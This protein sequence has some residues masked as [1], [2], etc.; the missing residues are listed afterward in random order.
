MP[1]RFLRPLLVVEFL[2]A[3]LAWLT[4]WS[5]VGGQYHLDLMFWPWKL[6][7][8]IAAAA[9]VCAFTADLVRN[10]GSVS[11]RAVLYVALLVIL[12][13]TA[14]VVTY[15]YHVNE[16]A[17]DQQDASQPTAAK[18]FQPY[19][20]RQA[21][22]ETMG[23]PAAQLNVFWNSGRFFTTPLTRYRSMECPSVCA[24]MV[25]VSGV[26]LVHHS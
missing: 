5:Q 3:I 6:G 16:P 8:T 15:Y 9:V 21:L 25:S 19:Q 22:A 12:T 23:L 26:E 10:E 14:G 13:I 2:I 20:T 17:D 24:C 11:R 18:L 4:L 1:S 7:L